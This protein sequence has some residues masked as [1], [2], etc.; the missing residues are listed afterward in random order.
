M[1]ALPDF[2]HRPPASAVTLGRLSKMMPITPMGTVMREISRPLGLV[3][4]SVMRPTGSFSS[5]MSSSP[6]A[7]A[8]MRA[9]VRVRRSTKDDFKSLA[10]APSK[11]LALAA[12]ISFIAARTCLAMPRKAASL[13]VAGAKAS[14]FA[15][16]R[17]R[18]PSSI[19]SLL[20]T[21][22]DHLGGSIHRRGPHRQAFARQL[23]SSP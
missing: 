14:D 8:S 4:F 7:M 3:H 12:R 17:A 2:T 23:I 18:F 22:P 5:A 1:A 16:A 10:F 19:I 6:L 15:A 11:S 21:S 9:G 20:I 13:A